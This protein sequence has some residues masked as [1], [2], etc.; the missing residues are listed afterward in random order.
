MTASGGGHDVVGSFN[1]NRALARHRLCLLAQL[2]LALRDHDHV[3]NANA[4]K[5]DASERNNRCYEI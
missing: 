4:C 5:Y 2:S 1:L 3:K